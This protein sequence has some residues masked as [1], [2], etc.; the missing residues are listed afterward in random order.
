[1]TYWEVT[2]I[3]DGALGDIDQYPTEHGAMRRIEHIKSYAEKDT[4]VFTQ[5]Y[6]LMHEHSINQPE[7]ECIQ[8]EWDLRPHWSNRVV[9]GRRSRGRRSRG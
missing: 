1:M 3:T 7:C 5:V 6:L 2:E 8:Y 9:P 4:K